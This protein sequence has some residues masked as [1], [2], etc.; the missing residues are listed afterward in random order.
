MKHSIERLSEPAL[1]LGKVSLERVFALREYIILNSF[2]MD[3]VFGKYT[4]ILYE[5]A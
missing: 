2:I 5:K 1:E 3:V 4:T